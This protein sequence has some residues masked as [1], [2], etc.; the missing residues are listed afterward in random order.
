MLTSLI[1]RLNI[2]CIATNFDDLIWGFLD[3]IIAKGFYFCLCEQAGCCGQIANSNVIFET[4]FDQLFLKWI[5]HARS[6]LLG[7]LVNLD[8]LAISSLLWSFVW[9]YGTSIRRLSSLFPLS[10]LNEMTFS[11]LVATFSFLDFLDKPPWI[12]SDCS[13]LENRSCCPLK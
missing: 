9:T 5:T 4:I 6:K 12:C 13:F 3:T 11:S 2:L 7:F 10:T 1:S 8:K